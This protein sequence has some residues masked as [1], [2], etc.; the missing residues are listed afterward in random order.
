M[1]DDRWPMTNDPQPSVIAHW[2]SAIGHRSL[3]IGHRSSRV[4]GEP[5]VKVPRETDRRPWGWLGLAVIAVA[6]G[7]GTWMAGGG[8]ANPDLVW[9]QAEIDFRA[10][11]YDRADAALTR[12]RRLRAPTALDWML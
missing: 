6:G 9:K 1:A 8:N 7:V 10:K 11:R 3:A 2:S 5:L 12:L 4:A